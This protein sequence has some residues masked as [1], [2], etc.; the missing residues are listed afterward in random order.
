MLARVAREH[1]NYRGPV[2]RGLPER[3]D[4]LAA[5]A[6]PASPRAR[7]VA[8]YVAALA[9]LAGLVYGSH[10]VHGGLYWDDWRNAATTRYSPEGFAGPFDL[11]LIAYRPLLGLTLPL[12]HLAFGTAAGPHIALALALAVAVSACVVAVLRRLGLARV[13]AA[14]IGALAL[15]FPWSD[16]TRLWATGG[17]NN[18]AVA[19]LLLAL[20]A[21]LAG[22]GAAGRRRIA[23]RIAS[24]ALYA[25]SVLTYEATAVAA[26]LS[27]PIYAIQVG[28]RPALAWWRVDA[29]AVVLATVAR[30]GGDDAR[31]ARARR[32]ARARR[33]GRRRRRRADRR[34]TRPASDDALRTRRAG[35]P[36]PD[37]ARTPRR[38][39]RAPAWRGAAPLGRRRGR[40]AGPDRRRLCGVRARRGRL[41]PA[42]ARDGEPGERARG[43][44]DRD[45]RLRPGTDRRDTASRP[46]DEPSGSWPWS[47]WARSLSA[48]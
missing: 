8:L 18:L 37:R 13:H 27:L 2:A 47:W 43:P 36:P 34:G 31:A 15:V 4:R 26:L 33:G 44:R 19:L 14:A 17:I 45:A 1:P 46:A 41:H 21:G 12:P 5:T 23:L 20:L 40:R 29:L 3:G 48:T 42:R 16:S 24:P 25:L 28:W 22:L 39:P 32:R 9:A 30:R 6:R 11:R 10:V 38:R 7:E 35:G